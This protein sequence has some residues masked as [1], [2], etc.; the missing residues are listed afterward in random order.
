MNR[1]ARRDFLKQASATGL[2]T[3]LPQ[4]NKQP[5]V[6]EGREWITTGPI[7][8]E[9]TSFDDAMQTF[10]QARNIS[11]GV[12][13]I[14]YNSKLVLARGYTYSND[15]EDIVVEPTSLFRMAS[16]SKPVTGTAVLRLVQDGQLDLSAQLTDLITLTPPAGQTSDP[17]LV[18]ITVLDLLQHLAG[19]DCD[20][21]F[22]PMFYDHTIANALGIPL[23][24]SKTDIATYMT[25]QPLQHTPRTTFAY[26][27][28]GF[29]LLGQITEA[30]TGQSYESYVKQ[31]LFQPLAIYNMTLGRSLPAY[32]LPNEVKYHTQYNGIT[33]FDNSGTFVPLCYGGWK[34][35]NMDSHGAWLGTAVELARFASTFDDP[36]TSP[37]LNSS[38]V[39]MMYGLPQHIDPGDY[40]PGDWYYGCGWSVRD[41]GSGV[42]NTWHDGSLSG[43]H[44]LLVRRWDGV[45]YC[46][47]FNQRD[48]A[49]GLP[50]WEI[51][52]LLYNAADKISLWPD[53]D[54]FD[55]Y[56]LTEKV[57]LPV[58][59][60]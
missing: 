16:L 25:G 40:T 32:R 60:K 47:L 44:A 7:I 11:G 57:Y 54:L 15:S 31:K 8:P 2:L 21:A 42:R 10:M 35:E 6:E 23:P 58:I 49:S 37:I 3:L 26:S 34:L 41:W 18:D 30:V 19:W 45:N 14:T 46:V 53:H 27:N 36:V 12:L 55:D 43:T 5:T 56:L 9:L 17:G 24:I 48:D 13:A 28:Y 50:Y 59:M 33:V 20:I 52:P 38:S 4:S 1:I 39:E 51:D 22:D 29:S